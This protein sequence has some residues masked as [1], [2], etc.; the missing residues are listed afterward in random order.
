MC[1]ADVQQ[2]LAMSPND[3][4]ALNQRGFI[5]ETMDRNEDA[6]AD[7]RAALALNQSPTANADSRAGLR[8]LGV[9][10]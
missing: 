9:R 4:S 8:R 10:P 2:S 5:Y 7:F 1:V 3:A 6:I